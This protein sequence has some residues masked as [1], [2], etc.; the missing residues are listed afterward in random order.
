MRPFKRVRETNAERRRELAH[1]DPDSDGE[2]RKRPRK[3]GVSNTGD[4]Q[5]RCP[6]LHHQIATFASP[7]LTILSPALHEKAFANE[8][9]FEI[10][11]ITRKLSDLFYDC[12][13][14][15]SEKYQHWCTPARVPVAH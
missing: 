10:G 12:I 1:S 15:K 8:S 13:R 5:L 7:E 9:M 11:P 14:G 3:A 4:G 6:S 2:K